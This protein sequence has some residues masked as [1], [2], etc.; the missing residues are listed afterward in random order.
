[1]SLLLLSGR[2][3][4]LSA[5]SE[6]LE[7]TINSPGADLSD[8][9][10]WPSP[11]Q[12]SSD[13][14]LAL[15]DLQLLL[16]QELAS[17]SGASATV[18][19]LDWTLGTELG[20]KALTAFTAP[21][22][23]LL[24]VDRLSDLGRP[25]FRYVLRWREGDREIAIT[26]FGPYIRHDAT[27]RVMHLDARTV[28][29]VEG[30]EQ[31]NALPPE[32][33]TQGA[34]WGTFARI[35]EDA[36][37]SG[38]LLDEYLLSN[39][40]VIPTTIGL[41]IREHE[42]GSISFE[43]RVPELPDAATF[44]AKFMD[45]ERHDLPEVE[46][47]TDAS[48]RRVR[49]L[50]S[51]P[52]RE[53]LRRIRR[54]RGV[55]GPDADRL[56]VDPAA[57]FDGVA[58]HIDLANIGREYGPRVIGIGKL[59]L[60]T[61]VKV[62]GGLRISDI[63][64]IAKPEAL[65]AASDEEASSAS[66]ETPVTH[67]RS[68]VAIDVLD[69]ETKRPLTLRFTNADEVA[70]VL[71]QA[72][73]ALRTGES[74]M[75]YVGRRVVVEPAL[76]EALSAHVAP[77]SARHRSDDI[78]VVGTNGH[79]YLLID[80]H[81]ETLTPALLVNPQDDDDVQATDSPL[82]RTLLTGVTLQPH[83]REGVRWLAATHAARGRRGGILADDMGLGKTLQILTHVAHLIES[84]AIDDPTAP[85]NN[86]PWRPVLIIAPLL[87]VE[88]GIWTEE[89]Q[90]HFADEGRVFEPWVVLRDEG[91]E[92]VRQPTTERDF[93]GKPLLDPARIMRHKVVITTYETLVAY[94]H[95]LAQRIGGRPMWSLV[96][97]DEAQQIKSPATKKSYAAKAVDARFKIAATGT[98]VE[99]RLRDLWNLLD[100]VEPTRLGTQRHFVETYEKPAQNA[101]DATERLQALD[102]LR[103]ALHYQ[104]PSAYLL[105]RDKSVLKSLPPKIEHRPR[106]DMTADER[107]IHGR[108]M[109]SMVGTGAGKRA[110]AALNGLHLATQHP[111]L[112]GGKGSL[113]D[114]SGLIASS[115]RLGTLVEIL[116]QIEGVG[117]KALIFARSVDA[118]RLLADV[119]GRVF[120]R[121]I[122]VING[123]TGSEN[124]RR[125]GGTGAARRQVL[126]RFRTEPGFGAI[127]LS[128][129]VAGVG[130]T[131][132]E[133]NHVIH[134]GRWWNPAVEG[135]ATDRAFR[136]G[137]QRP[138]HVY[139][140]ILT[141]PTGQIR[142]TF[143]EAL[144][145]L[146]TSRR[147]LATDFLSPRTEDEEGAALLETLAATD[148]SPATGKPEPPELERLELRDIAA[149]LMET[150]RIRGEQAA[151]L[152]MEGRLGAH[153]LRRASASIKA[154]R[155]AREA[156]EPELEIA[157]GAAESWRSVLGVE[158]VEAELVTHRGDGSGSGIVRSWS[159]I[160]DEAKA[161]GAEVVST[162]AATH[163]VC[164]AARARSILFPDGATLV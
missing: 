116:R 152:G 20:A 72:R 77:D 4:S 155:I 143:D 14:A 137:Q 102:R 121:R 136:I 91:L 107:E 84:G 105:R 47:L 93:L 135:Q 70:A 48:G 57:A 74:A 22:H 156:S 96:V 40:V 67:K 150:A 101:T 159:T 109:A 154:I 148:G 127:I 100:T 131:L 158:R 42:D 18:S 140:P 161:A 23:L 10:T 80:E 66:N 118:Q 19:P 123:E 130:L 104:R 83:Q 153:V 110:L 164:D 1:M 26:R 49:I 25:D 8:P 79:L 68:T 88:S 2:T 108:L 37:A 87:L 61:D 129:F 45:L 30:M 28:A 142:Q 17:P 21:S 89:M 38:A 97:F 39:T 35:R 12:L 29:L 114:T 141:D 32:R 94:Q 69:A 11:S 81:E 98:P 86:G 16:E 92:K 3:V 160:V 51:E 126:H 115:S 138:V 90:R 149:L 71:E 31:F 36:A 120:D 41:I 60:P 132:V 5:N 24:T 55:S 112:A 73:A 103:S 117:E 139:Y 147:G 82:P 111:V 144:D 113:S 15:T 13:E 119:L 52:Q 56:K 106:C 145:A 124:P 9:S 46:T 75:E 163:E 65:E 162:F 85:G 128:P 78:G 157:R 34:A 133:A 64:G 27:G 43:P 44:T 134:Y 53:V 59:K 58:D 125:L 95:S 122:D 33:R 7:F 99:T 54:V 62:D 76:V 63:L 6:G 50:F 151:W 146:I